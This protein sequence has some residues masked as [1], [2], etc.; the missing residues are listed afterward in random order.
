MG[1]GVTGW[2]G[3]ITYT[4]E[5]A[6]FITLSSTGSTTQTGAITIMATPTENTGVERT[7]T[8]TL[9][10]TGSTGTAD[11]T[12]TQEVGTPPVPDAPTLMLTSGNTVDVAN[13]ATSSDSIEITFVVGGGFDR[14]D[15]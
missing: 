2:T 13:T 11:I 15:R 5:N 6:N 14:L 12:I 3:T 4:P 1:C 9:T 8:I 10:T 7:A